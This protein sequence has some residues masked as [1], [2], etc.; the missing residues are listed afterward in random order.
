MR[1]VNGPKWVVY[2]VWLVSFVAGGIAAFM[3]AGPA[4]FADGDTGERI[5]VLG[6]SVV[7]FAALGLVAGLIAPQGW[8]GSGLA[9]V[10]PVVL[11]ALLF[12][13]EMWLLAAM[14][15][16]SNAAAALFGAWMGARVRMRR[17]EPS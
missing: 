16:L 1:P 2:V 17:A 3:T 10:A 9:L 13:L 7:V 6:V 15:V 14:F 8:K 11:V 12:G 5:V 4:L